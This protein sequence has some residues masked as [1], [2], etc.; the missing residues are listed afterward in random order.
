MATD[1]KAI[2]NDPDAKP[3]MIKRGVDGN[4]ELLTE[5]DLEELPD[6]CGPEDPGDGGK[7]AGGGVKNRQDR[8]GNVR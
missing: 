8:Q 3:R 6:D 4:E 1:P 5:E 2:P 7:P